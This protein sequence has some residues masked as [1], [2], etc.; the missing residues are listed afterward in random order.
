MA[1]LHETTPDEL[2]YIPEGLA[3]CVACWN[4]I[5]KL[6]VKVFDFGLPQGLQAVD[7]SR[8]TG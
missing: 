1:G 2:E 6:L 5:S 3:E 7:A 4:L 8:R